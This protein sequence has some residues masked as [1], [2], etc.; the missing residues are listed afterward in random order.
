M[1][2]PVQTLSDVIESLYHHY[3][4]FNGRCTPHFFVILFDGIL[5]HKAFAV[6]NGLIFALML[7]LFCLNF[8]GKKERYFTVASIVIA[9]M[10]ILL[11]AF[12]S[13]MLW[14][15][16]ACNYLWSAVFVLFFHYLLS[17]DIRK[18]WWVLLFI[19]GIIAGNTNEGIM[20]GL[21]VGYMVYYLSHFKEL[22]AQRW[23]MLIG[24]AI[25]VAFLVFAPSV[26][27]TALYGK[28]GKSSVF[29]D[30]LGFFAMHIPSYLV[31]LR[32][33]YIALF[34]ML[35][36]KQFPLL[37][38]SAMLTLSVFCFLVSAS[39]ATTYFGLEICSL[40]VILQV[41]DLG[42]IRKR[43]TVAMSVVAIAVLVLALPVC[44]DNYS[45]FR[46]IDNALH[47][48]TQKDA[49]IFADSRGKDVTYI[50]G[51]FLVNQ[52]Q[53][54]P[55]RKEVPQITCQYY[56]KSD[57]RIF[58]TALCDLLS[59]GKVS[60]EFDLHTPYPY[61]VCEWDGED[62]V[63][64]KITYNPSPYANYPL[65]NRI[66]KYTINEQDIAG[67]YFVLPFRSKHYL[68]IEKNHPIADR[69][70]SIEVRSKE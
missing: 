56:D 11:P 7:H 44:A 25:G 35:R 30:G 34:L 16:G 23:V 14:M 54:S 29:K 69:I 36:K 13:A 17:K 60:K 61:Y 66:G 32:I 26:W 21:S 37:W 51:R 53:C 2:R 63:V 58:P 19:Y 12:Q 9:S 3:F 59:S 43:H 10:V 5:G 42:S 52:F 68:V 31:T 62:E 55:F 47:T 49:I 70:K 28:V 24:L 65:L 20:I 8:A 4:V 67:S 1:Q 64:G 18:R 41:V 57:I 48:S 33:T 38:G 39:Y 27:D 6:C 46:I 50:S 22:T 15:S 40:A 45:R